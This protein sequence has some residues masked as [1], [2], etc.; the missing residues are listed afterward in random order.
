MLSCLLLA[1]AQWLGVHVRAVFFRFQSEPQWKKIRQIYSLLL[2]QIETTSVFFERDYTDSKAQGGTHQAR[3][4]S[5]QSVPAYL[6]DN[7]ISVIG[8]DYANFN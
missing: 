8:Y 6:V 7:L 2:H 4:I 1:A 5:L 3:K